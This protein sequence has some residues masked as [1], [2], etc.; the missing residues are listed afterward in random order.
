VEKQE[1][2]IC[3]EC[4]TKEC[5]STKKAVYN[6][7]ICGKWFCELHQKPKLPYF[8]D[9]E[10]MFDVQ[11]NPE[12]KALFYSEYKRLDGHPDFVYLKQTIEKLEREKLI[13]NQLIEKNIDKMVEANL[14][15]G[16]KIPQDP[17][18]QKIV[19]LQ[20]KYGEKFA[21]PSCIYSNPEY[22][23][24]LDHA[25]S[26]KSV[27]VIVDEYQKKYGDK[28]N[29]SELLPKKKHWWQK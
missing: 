23:E 28:L 19:S 24:Y 10:S 16:K 4:Q 27:K 29:S 8:V 17:V 22:R 13:Q 9:W 3:Y 18:K 21:I 1:T 14:K 25:E 7:D 15:R 20:E 2:G 26:M 12:V 6:C 11:G 5:D